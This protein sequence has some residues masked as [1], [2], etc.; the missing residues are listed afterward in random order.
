[1]DEHYEYGYR[2]GLNDGRRDAI[3]RIFK[4]SWPR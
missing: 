3:T 2:M 4:T 1:M